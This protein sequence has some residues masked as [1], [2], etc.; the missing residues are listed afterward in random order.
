MKRK[1]KANL[2]R[3]VRANHALTRYKETTGDKYADAATALTDLLA[4]LLHLSDRKAG[5]NFERC[6]ETA[7]SHHREETEER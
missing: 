7:R 5:I 4:D 2:D 6:L 3:A 1:G